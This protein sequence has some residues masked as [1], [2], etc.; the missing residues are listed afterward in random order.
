MAK[1]APVAAALPAAVCAAV[2]SHPGDC[3]LTAY[4]KGAHASDSLGE[5]VRRVLR[6]RG[7]AGLFVGLQ[8]RAAAAPP[9]PPP[10]PP[11]LPPPPPPPRR[12]QTTRTAQG[13]PWPPDP[14]LS[15]APPLLTL[16][17]WPR[18]SRRPS[19]R[20]LSAPP[21][22][23]GAAAPRHR[24]HLGAARHVRPAQGGARATRDGRPLTA[25]RN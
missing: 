7:V 19:P 2:L 9:P 23:P 14:L 1:L 17:P 25:A 12:R 20:A 16:I 11:P 4:Y 8:A 5:S 24:H 18:T 15:P 10:P 21:L 6:E 22:S 3:L 13:P